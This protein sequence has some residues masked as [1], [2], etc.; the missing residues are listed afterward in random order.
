MP[1]NQEIYRLIVVEQYNLGFVQ[2][3]IGEAQDAGRGRFS[4]EDLED[5]EKLV[6]EI[7]RLEA[8]KVAIVQSSAAEAA[9]L[10]WIG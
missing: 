6:W 9:A 7:E 4:E 8:G 10:I 1:K 3:I 2:N 5:L